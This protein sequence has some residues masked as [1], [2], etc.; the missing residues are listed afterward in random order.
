MGCGS[1]RPH[2]PVSASV[3]IVDLTRTQ[4][5][6]LSRL[7]LFVRSGPAHLTNATARWE[8]ATSTV[9]GWDPEGRSGWTADVPGAR[10]A[11]YFPGPAFRRPRLALGIVRT[12]QRGG[13][14]LAVPAGGSFPFP[15]LLVLARVLL[16][17]SGVRNPR[18]EVDGGSN[19]IPLCR[20][21]GDDHAGWWTP[22]PSRRHH[23]HPL[24]GILPA[25]EA[26]GGCVVSSP[27]RLSLAWDSPWWEP[28]RKNC[29]G[30][31]EKESGEI[32][33]GLEWVVAFEELPADCGQRGAFRV[34][35]DGR[36]TRAADPDSGP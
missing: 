22:L 1:S 23:H 17:S 15:S 36:V 27:S 31:G 10:R 4:Q 25:L 34:Y 3:S 9:G 11:Y 5:A 35:G 20:V 26:I 29:C 18:L 21:P 7:P 8:A 19:T 28:G 30:G 14:L 6:A 2:S 12:H 32:A 24:A 13:E 16:M 33:V